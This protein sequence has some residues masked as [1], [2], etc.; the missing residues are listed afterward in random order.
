MSIARPPR[1]SIFSALCLQPLHHSKGDGVHQKNHQS[2]LATHQSPS[3]NRRQNS[4]HANFRAFHKASNL[5]APP[6]TLFD[7]FHHARP[8]LAFLILPFPIIPPHSQSEATAI[9]ARRHPSRGLILD[10]HRVCAYCTDA[11]TATDLAAHALRAQSPPTVFSSWTH[12]IFD[13]TAPSATLRYPLRRPS[14]HIIDRVWGSTS[15]SSQL[16]TA[17]C[18]PDMHQP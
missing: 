1:H 12:R 3:G 17:Y 13:A 11:T 14:T 18:P 5:H 9:A 4:I 16:S 7:F 8:P 10:L 2:P 6:S 15:P